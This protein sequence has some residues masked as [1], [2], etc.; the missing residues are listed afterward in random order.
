MYINFF[1]FFPCRFFI[2]VFFFSD[3]ITLA[4]VSLIRSLVS[5]AARLRQ[6]RIVQGFLSLLYLASKRLYMIRAGTISSRRRWY[7]LY[8]VCMCV[9]FFIYLFFG[10]F[11][12]VD[13]FFFSFRCFLDFQETERSRSSSL[14]VCC[15]YL[16]GVVKRIMRDWGDVQAPVLAHDFTHFVL[17]DS[18]SPRHSIVFYINLPYV[19]SVLTGTGWIRHS[20][21]FP[22]SVC[23]SRTNLLLLSVSGNDYF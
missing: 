1:F 12:I 22:L 6:N 9:F 16:I 11:F 2:F 4:S 23:W 3:L 18:S 8:S 15:T 10:I 13:L 20:P 5:P 19:Y 21:A 14:Y 7:F 17:T